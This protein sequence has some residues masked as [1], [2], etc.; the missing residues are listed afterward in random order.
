MNFDDDG[1]HLSFI[2]IFSFFHFSGVKNIKIMLEM[3][4]IFLNDNFNQH[5]ESK[6]L[7]LGDMFIKNRLQVIY[8]WIMYYQQLFKLGDSH[9]KLFPLFG[10]LCSAITVQ[11]QKKQSNRSIYGE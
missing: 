7:Q 11:F 9:R 6:V 10:Y 2:F 4:T 1:I 5:C 3:A 8:D